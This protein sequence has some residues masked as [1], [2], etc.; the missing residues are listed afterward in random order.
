MK[1]ITV[2]II[3]TGIIAL[4]FLPEILYLTQP[5]QT[6]TNWSATTAQAIIGLPQE[7]KYY[8]CIEMKPLLGKLTYCE[9]KQ[10]RKLNPE[11]PIV[12]G[13]FHPSKDL[14]IMDYKP[15]KRHIIHELGHNLL[16]CYQ[17][18]K[19]NE[20]CVRSNDKLIED[21]KVLK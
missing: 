15:M 13:E 10:D 12:K 6:V 21:L 5:K 7:L 16:D 18:Y 4:S 1:T 9:L 2:L 17:N 11:Q 20:M 14:I 19:E 8:N 3:L